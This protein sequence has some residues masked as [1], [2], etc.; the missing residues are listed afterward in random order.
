MANGVRRGP[1]MERLLH[2]VQN[3]RGPVSALAVVG[4]GG[5]G[6]SYL[7]ARVL[8]EAAPGAHGALVLRADGAN[9]QARGDFFGVLGQLAPHVLPRPARPGR[10][11]FPSL[12]RLE[13]AHRKLVSQARAELAAT[14]GAPPVVK[15]AALKLLAAGR[16]LNRTVPRTREFLDLDALPVDD[17]TAAQAFDAAWELARSLDALGDSGVLPGP[18]RDALGLS[19]RT[20]VREDLYAA[21][22]EALVTD[23]SAAITG[24]VMKDA[25]KVLQARIDGV[26]RLLLIVDDFEVLAPV[27]QEF[28]VGALLPKL[29]AARFPTSIVLLCRDPLDAMHPAWGQHAGE[30]LR[31]TITLRAFSREDA[32]ALLRDVGVPDDQLDGLYAATQGFPFLLSLMAEE[33]RSTGESALF[34]KK[35]YDRTTRWMSP[36]EREWFERVC[37]LEVVNLDTLPR[38]VEPQEAPRVQEWFE[39]EASIRDPSARVFAVRPLIREKCLRYLELRSPSRHRELLAR[40]SAAA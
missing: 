3:P 33:A 12:R 5:V 6:K 26:D 18:V 38:V 30:Y 39:R 11:Y 20:R 24:W 29:A 34:L 37:Y 35:F 22:A 40:A 36:R 1:E 21:A 13:R 10:D 2:F 15:D 31:D 16:V 25:F 14:S 27:L 32:L 19:L 7:L 8:E 9:P 4:P 23:L 28:L 17:A